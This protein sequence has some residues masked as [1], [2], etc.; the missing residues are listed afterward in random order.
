[1]CSNKTKPQKNDN[2]KKKDIQF[3]SSW[4]RTFSNLKIS[5][6][7]FGRNTQHTLLA[8]IFIEASTSKCYSEKKRSPFYFLTPFPF[9]LCI[10]KLSPYNRLTPFLSSQ[11]IHLFHLKSNHTRCPIAAWRQAD[12]FMFQCL[13]SSKHMLFAFYSV[14]IYKS[15]TFH[16]THGNVCA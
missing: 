1:M 15:E 9:L 3:H 4:R 6:I 14:F 13:F 7:L 16:A 10:W 11:Q 5:L 12:W 2:Y 8:L